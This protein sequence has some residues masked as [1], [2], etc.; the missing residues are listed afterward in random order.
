MFKV[1]GFLGEILPLA[2]GS[3]VIAFD[4]KHQQTPALRGETPASRVQHLLSQG[5]LRDAS[6]VHCF[7]QTIAFT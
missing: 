2:S 3:S 6:L 7:P 5:C 4:P 1:L